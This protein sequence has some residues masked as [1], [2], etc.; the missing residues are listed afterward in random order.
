MESNVFW[1]DIVQQLIMAVFPIILSIAVFYLKQWKDAIVKEAEARIDEKYID[2]FKQFVKIAV[3]AA[4]Q[5]GYTEKIENKYEEV[6][7]HSMQW[8]KSKGIDLPEDQ[9]QLMI[10][11]AVANMKA[12]GR[13]IN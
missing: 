1:M 4:E 6:F 11:S 2:Q 7:S 5:L 8:L 13:E 10:E 3:E 9:V 12:E